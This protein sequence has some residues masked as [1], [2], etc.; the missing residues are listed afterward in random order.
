MAVALY[1]ALIILGFALLIKGADFLV[2][3]ASS[4]AKRFNISELA[5]GLTIVAL[6]T[7]APELVVNIISGS[8]GYSEVVFG[9]II[10]SNIFNLFLILGV[11]GTIY[12]LAVQKKTVLR[13]LPFLL[14]VTL[15]LFYLVNDSLF[16]N[17]P[18]NKS[19]SI[20][21]FILL[22]LFMV[23]LIYVFYNMKSGLAEENNIKIYTP[24][25]TGLRIVGG[26]I[27]L[28]VGGKLVVDNAVE[29]ANIYEVSEK[30]IGLTIIAAGTS[31]PELATSAVAAYKKQADIAIG[32]VVGSN[33]FNIL[34]VL[35]VSTMISPLQYN[36]E[37]NTDMY[38]LIAGTVML[39]LFMFTVNKKKLDRRESFLYLLSF[40]GYMIYLFIRK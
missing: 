13:E 7:S 20:D 21:G 10:G 18:L 33:I 1:F 3:G 16:H 37:L 2:S 28:I 25:I 6:G 22:G 40:I 5:I 15:I 23:F 36:S 30:L 35:G 12:P 26:L 14:F 38:M 17:E 32:N 4:L 29:V 19:S 31:L 11:A 39:L 34:L 9:N 27:G 24:L 8:Q